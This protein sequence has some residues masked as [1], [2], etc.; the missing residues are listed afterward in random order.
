MAALLVAVATFLPAQATICKYPGG[1]C[2]ELR[3]QQCDGSSTW[4][5]H[6]LW[7]QW[8]DDCSGEDFDIDKLDSIRDRLDQDWYSCPEYHDSNTKFWQHE[9]EKHGT[10]TGM[11]Q[12]DYFS[13][14]L[15]LYSTYR[16]TCGDDDDQCDI[17]LSRDFSHREKCEGSILVKVNTSVAKANASIIV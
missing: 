8:D 5:I 6:G 9:W 14:G 11:S 16:S 1:S 12:V 7:P 13:K 17:C 2:Y 4:T 15:N 10:C 3:L